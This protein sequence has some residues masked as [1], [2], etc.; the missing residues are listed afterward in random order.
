VKRVPVGL[1]FKEKREGSFGVNIIKQPKKNEENNRGPEDK[2][3]SIG[4]KNKCPRAKEVA[5]K[6][7][8]GGIKTKQGY[9]SPKDSVVKVCYRI[10]KKKKKKK[11][12]GPA[13]T[14][15]I[16][17]ERKPLKKVKKKQNKKDNNRKEIPPTEQG[18][19]ES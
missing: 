13:S 19:K 6:K 3:Q 5:E 2:P 12:T 15:G 7:K 18:G 17:R 9:V 1:C 8:K 14:G 4:E 16:R 10:H 11:K